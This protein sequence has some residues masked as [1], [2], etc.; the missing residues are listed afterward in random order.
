MANETYTLR[1]RRLKKGSLSYQK[2]F[3]CI[4]KRRH[5]RKIGKNTQIMYKNVRKCKFAIAKV[6]KM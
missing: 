3:F 4:F 5:E 2:K 1:D 6:T